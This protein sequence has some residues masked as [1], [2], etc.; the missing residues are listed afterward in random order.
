VWSINYHFK[1]TGHTDAIGSAEF[2]LK[3]SVQRAE[4]VLDYLVTKHHIAANRLSIEGKGFSE[5]ADVNHPESG[6]NRRVQV[7][8]V[9]DS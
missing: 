8:N 9:G 5:P 6:V 7:T 1:L 3:L 4:S 2:N